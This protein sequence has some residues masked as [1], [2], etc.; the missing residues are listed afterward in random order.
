M[1]A[2]QEAARKDFLIIGGRRKLHSALNGISTGKLLLPLSAA[3]SIIK[4]IQ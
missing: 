4:N 3:G 1:R 2:Q